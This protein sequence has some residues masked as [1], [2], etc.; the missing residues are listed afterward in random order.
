MA[1]LLLF[2]R[3]KHSNRRS[4]SIQIVTDRRQRGARHDNHVGCANCAESV[5]REGAGSALDAEDFALAVLGSGERR[6]IR[7]VVVEEAVQTSTVDNNIF[8]VQ[9]AQAQSI[10][11]S[12]AR[13]AAAVVWVVD[14]RVDRVRAVGRV[15]VGLIV[16]RIVLVGYSPSW[17]GHIRC[18]GLKESSHN[19]A[20]A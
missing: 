11:V 8:A 1:A 5:H 16:S 15:G 9:D 7:A 3:S 19:G 6:A 18:F 17:P 14:A 10:A 13:T 2:L 20:C 12:S 4:V